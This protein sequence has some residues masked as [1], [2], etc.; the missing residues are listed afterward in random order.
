MGSKQKGFIAM[1]SPMRKTQLLR[2]LFLALA[3]GSAIGSAFAAS[4]ITYDQ[5]KFQEAQAKAG[6]KIILDFHSTRCS[7]CVKAAEALS[8]VLDE[9]QF[10]DVQWHFVQYEGT[11]PAGMSYEVDHASLLLFQGKDQVGALTG[12]LDAKKLRKEL[13]KAFKG[14]SAPAAKAKSESAAH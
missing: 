11:L 3:L 14:G 10:K 13:H 5:A 7:S 8:K 12:H 2:P 6:Q 1:I 4:P 9:K